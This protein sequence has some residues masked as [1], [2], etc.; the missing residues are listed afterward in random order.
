MA[1]IAEQEALHSSQQAR[2]EK[3]CRAQ[4]REAV[5]QVV[6]HFTP[7]A[8]DVSAAPPWPTGGE[9]YAKLRICIDQ[10]L[11]RAMLSEIPPRELEVIHEAQRRKGGTAHAQVK[12]PPYQ[13]RQLLVQFARC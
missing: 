2:P 9:E 7:T 3:D 13:M 11:L 5:Y 6:R 10:L 12:T 4:A 1:F 8:Y